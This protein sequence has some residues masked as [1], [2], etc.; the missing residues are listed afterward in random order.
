MKILCETCVKNTMTFPSVYCNRTALMDPSKP[1][2]A[3][4]RTECSGYLSPTVNAMIEAQEANEK[5][6]S[7]PDTPSHA[8]RRAF[9]R[10]KGV[11]PDNILLPED[12]MHA[13][14]WEYGELVQKA[15]TEL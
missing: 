1:E 10:F 4:H 3:R 11:D 12:E 13:L 15:W 6:K 5:P 14:N 7:I 9:Y 2:S 8:G